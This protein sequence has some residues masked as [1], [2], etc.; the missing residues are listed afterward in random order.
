[1]SRYWFTALAAAGLLASPQVFAAVSEAEIR[2]VREQLAALSERLDALETENAELRSVQAQDAE[3]I[4]D[5]QTNLEEVQKAAAPVV[6]D[7]WTDRI[8]LDGDF[9][10][11]YEVIDAEDSSTRRRN[12]IR[13]RTNVRA[14]VSDDV[15][16]GFGLATGG[17]DPV[18]TN[19]TLGGGGSSKRVSLNLAY[20]DWEPV[21][22]LH[23]IGGKFKN[24][25]HR[26]GKQALL[27][28][29]DWTPEGFSLTY[30]RSWYFINGFGSFLESDTRGSNDTFSWGAQFGASGEFA[31]ATLTGGLSYY[32]IKT[33]GEQTTFGDPTDPGDYFGNTAVQADGQPCGTTPDTDCFYLND[34]LLTEVFGEAKFALGD[35]PAVVFANYVKNS[36]A[37]D[38]DTGWTI[39]TRIGQTKDRGE[40][41]FSYFY[42]DK[43]ADAMLGLLTDSD[44]GGGGTD[45]RGHFFKL[46]YGVSKGW[47]IG[48]QY[49]INETDIS[50]GQK[51][52]YNRLMLDAQWKWK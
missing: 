15:E 47:V 5:V 36:D 35:W 16:I 23:I 4:A 39:G 19:Q 46:N 32:A 26:V 33:Q 41:E 30:E 50:S 6:A 27:W 3:A 13:A 28:D 43:E 8:S 42:A 17:D 40:F 52:D 1:M 7:S 45:N 38:N 25:L 49:F 10:Y 44:F 24:P 12:R 31:G 51:N 37:S 22:G 9:R 20:A 21:D 18:S 2:E 48:A 34:Y 29:G 11:R 14:E